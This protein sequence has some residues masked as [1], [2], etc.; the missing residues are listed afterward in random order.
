VTVIQDITAPQLSPIN[1]SAATLT[2]SS[3]SATL[4]GSSSTNGVSHRQVHRSDHTR[5][6]YPDRHQ[7]DQRLYKH[8]D[9]DH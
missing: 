9:R 8:H 7:P 1:P 2:C 5:F 6:L 3:P 4:T